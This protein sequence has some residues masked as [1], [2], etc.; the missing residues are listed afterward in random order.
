MK[1]ISIAKLEIFKSKCN[2]F[3]KGVH[4]IAYLDNNIAELI[5]YINAELGGDSYT[6]NPPTVTFKLYGKLLTIHEDKI[7]INALKDKEEGM[8]IIN[9]I[10]KEVNRIEKEKAYITPCYE[11][12]PKP[13][14]FQILKHL[15]KINCQECGYPTCMVFASLVVDG[16]KTPD[17]CPRIS[18]NAKQKLTKYLSQF[19]FIH[20]NEL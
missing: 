4:C 17:D 20:F 14:L 12:L 11:E 19:R 2:P 3:N 10:L 6:A 1:K 9:W 13:Q 16:I 7:A 5:P 18:E 15:P 8:K